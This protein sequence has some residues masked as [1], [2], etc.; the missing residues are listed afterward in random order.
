MCE[1]CFCVQNPTVISKG[2][3]RDER[4]GDLEG[5][6]L[7]LPLPIQTVL[8]KLRRVVHFPLHNASKSDDIQMLSNVWNETDYRFDA[9]TTTN[10]AHNE[11]R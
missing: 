8:Q 2:K 4:S 6:I 1:G 10:V 5:H 11:L 3:L 7:G 9:S